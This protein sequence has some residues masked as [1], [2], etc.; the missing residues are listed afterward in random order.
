MKTKFAICNCN[1][2]NS[3]FEIKIKDGQTVAVSPEFEKSP[4]F[5][6]GLRVGNFEFVEID[7]ISELKKVINVTDKMVEDFMGAPEEV[8]EVI[9]IV[10]ETVML[11]PEV[12]EVLEELPNDDYKS[13][14]LIVDSVDTGTVADEILPEI[15]EKSV[16]EVVAEIEKEDETPILPD[17]DSMKYRP[18]QKYASELEKKFH[19]EI[20]RGAKK[21][22]LLKEVKAVIEKYMK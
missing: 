7:I 15:I 13:V 8:P 9:T 19:V 11:A 6:E 22:D 4:E 2:E 21:A 16:E 17:V 12:P 18:L 5:Q 10:E 3:R 1:F 14:T 20:D